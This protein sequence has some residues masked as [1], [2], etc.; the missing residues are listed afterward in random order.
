MG[1]PILIDVSAGPINGGRE[2]APHFACL[3]FRPMPPQCK[4]LLCVPH[5]NGSAEDVVGALRQPQR[6]GIVLA[7]RGKRSARD[8]CWFLKPT[9]VQGVAVSSSPP[10]RKGFLLALQSGQSLRR[11][12]FPLNPTAAQGVLLAAQPNRS[13]RRFACALASRAARHSRLHLC[14]GAAQWIALAPRAHRGANIVGSASM[15]PQCKAFLRVSHPNGNQRHA[16]GALHQLQRGGFCSRCD[17][18]L[19]AAI[20]WF[21]SQPRCREFRCRLEPAAVQGL[22]PVLQS[23]QS[24]RRF[25]FPCNSTVVQRVSLAAQPNC[26][27]GRFACARPNMV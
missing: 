15:Q 1:D 4:S 19:C 14:K 5:P 21:P 6:E 9:A 8:C 25:A 23:G 12:A 2:T 27:V 18:K 3:L 20:C 10:Q 7:P 16:V 24:S 17:Q 13:A 11:F 22:V 26:S